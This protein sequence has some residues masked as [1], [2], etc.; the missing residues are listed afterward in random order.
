MSR[1]CSYPSS[2]AIVQ[3]SRGDLEWCRRTPASSLESQRPLRVNASFA[4]RS[5]NRGVEAIDHLGARYVAWSIAS[6]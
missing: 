1:S 2:V 5:R 3:A 6:Q 4:N